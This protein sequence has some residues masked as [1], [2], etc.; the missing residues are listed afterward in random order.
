M[1]I[2][3]MFICALI[4][5]RVDDVLDGNRLIVDV[6]NSFNK[7]V[8]NASTTKHYC[9]SNVDQESKTKRGDVVRFQSKLREVFD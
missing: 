7:V 4:D 5:G 8:D 9:V 1:M 2:R 6:N 3:C